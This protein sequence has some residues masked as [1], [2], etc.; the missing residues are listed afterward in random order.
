MDI[1]TWFSLSYAAYLV[2]PRSILQSMPDEWQERFVAC[3]QEVEEAGYTCPT[4][5]LTY[6]VNVRDNRTGRFEKDSYADYNR[7]RRVVKPKTYEEQLNDVKEA[8]WARELA[9]QAPDV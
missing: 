8:Q 4:P 6:S 9:R 2:L 5:G 3:L 1:H 7:G